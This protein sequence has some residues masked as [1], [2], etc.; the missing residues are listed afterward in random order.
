MFKKNRKKGETPV[1]AECKI[2]SPN[3]TCRE[4]LESPENCLCDEYR[5][6]LLDEH[7][8]DRSIGY[9]LKCGPGDVPQS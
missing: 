1:L 5:Q 6:E 7:E 3:G 2:I 9:C 8:F 4:C